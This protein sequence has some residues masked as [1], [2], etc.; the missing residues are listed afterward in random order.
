M[1]Q[2]PLLSFLLIRLLLG[3]L[4]GAGKAGYIE[5]ITLKAFPE[6]QIEEIV[7]KIY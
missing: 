7:T 6:K 5:T 3:T 2:W 4:L 1:I